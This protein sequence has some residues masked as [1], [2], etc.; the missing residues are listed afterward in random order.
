MKDKY[1]SEENLGLINL[2]HAIGLSSVPDLLRT[3]SI[4]DGFGINILVT[5]RRALGAA[6]LVNSLFNVP[7]ISKSRP[8]SLTVTK[9]EIIENGISLEVTTTTYHSDNLSPL[10]EYIDKLN[11]E[12]FENEQG[13]YKIHKDTRI[14]VCL[15][16]IPSDHFTDKEMDFMMKLSK[17]VNFIPIITKAD[18]YTNEELV[19][20]KQN[21]YNILQDNNISIFTSLSNTSP[22]SDIE[23]TEV[24][25]AVIASETVY[26]INNKIIRGRQYSWGFVDI[27]KEEGNDFKRLQRTLIYKN[28]DELINKT[29]IK[30]YNEYRKKILYFERNNKMCQERR[31]HKL[32][33]SLECVIK[34]KNEGILNK[35]RNEERNLDEMITKMRQIES[36]SIE[37]TSIENNSTSVVQ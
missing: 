36:T 22:D 5:G 1:F 19:L 35:L 18:M 14:H 20:R 16:L 25:H 28:F 11:N 32:K 8:N 17:L 29:H 10:A 30:Y 31:F 23:D 34:E 4:E 6:T 9:N 12:Y 37:S 26:E 27:D 2:S 33:E 21:I 15:Y 7:L 13:P 3:K 24:I